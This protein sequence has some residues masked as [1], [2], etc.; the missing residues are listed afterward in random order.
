MKKRIFILSIIIGLLLLT[1]CLG[2]GIPLGQRLTGLFKNDGKIAN[3][4]FA[5]VIV[6]IN[7]KDKQAMKKAFSNEVML[8]VNDFDSQIDYL[9]GF[10][11]GT[12]QEWGAIGGVENGGGS[13]GSIRDGVRR[14]EVYRG[15]TVKT[16]IET[17]EF[18]ITAHTQDTGDP[19]NIGIYKLT[20]YKAEDK[21]MWYRYG[22]SSCV[23]I[24]NPETFL[25][26]N[27]DGITEF[28]F[29]FLM[30]PF[31]NDPG[32]V[33]NYIKDVFSEKALEE[34]E[35]FDAG[36]AYVVDFC[37][38]MDGLSSYTWTKTVEV[39]YSNENGVEVK[40]TKSLFE[41]SKYNKFGCVK[42]FL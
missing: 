31:M 28:I 33:K 26:D 27:S 25:W 24:F 20:A 1:S 17:Y 29:K 19:N 3:E 42:D 4:Q 5:Q 11:Q 32:N 37:K 18:S 14:M 13:A 9:F 36:I 40:E 30:V 22:L 10:I 21:D 8:Q 23:G 16:D 35:N 12:I 15:Y 39:S 34:A 7:N 41:I 6:A 2:G 38:Y